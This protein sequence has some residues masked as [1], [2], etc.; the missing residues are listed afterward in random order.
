MPTS[1]LP[2]GKVSTLALTYSEL[3]KIPYDDNPLAPRRI[4]FGEEDIEYILSDQKKLA[5]LEAYSLGLVTLNDVKHILFGGKDF[6]PRRLAKYVFGNM[7]IEI[8]NRI[9][10]GRIAVPDGLRNRYPEVYNRNMKA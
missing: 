6:A 2:G 1:D 4:N 7:A 8:A 9:I 3:E 10:D 5:C